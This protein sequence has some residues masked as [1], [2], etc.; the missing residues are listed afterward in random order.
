[1]APK[2]QQNR[3]GLP[4]TW[5]AAELGQR[6]SRARFFGRVCALFSVCRLQRPPLVGWTAVET[7]VALTYAATRVVGLAAQQAGRPALIRSPTRV[8]AHPWE[9][10][11]A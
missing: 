11:L 4:P 7:R 10:L 9:G 8:L 1:V 2:C 5:T 3:T 6:T